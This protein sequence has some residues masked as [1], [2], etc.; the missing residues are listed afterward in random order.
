MVGGVDK[1]IGGQSYLPDQVFKEMG[2]GSCVVVSR[3]KD[4]RSS[5]LV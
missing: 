4:L 5:L 1:R 3:W 2:G